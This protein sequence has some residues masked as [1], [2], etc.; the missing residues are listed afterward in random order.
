MM[1]GMTAVAQSN[2][3]GWLIT[4]TGR[5]WKKVMNISL[6]SIARPFAFDARELVTS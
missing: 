3:I 4:S 1:C 2:Q 6:G 5:A